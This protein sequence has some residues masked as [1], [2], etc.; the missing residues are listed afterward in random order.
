LG[1]V[2][3]DV[4]QVA[5]PNVGKT[6]PV[7]AHVLQLFHKYLL[8]GGQGGEP[9]LES[10]DFFP[11]RIGLGACGL[12]PSCE[13]R[14]RFGPIQPELEQ[15]SHHVVVGMRK[16]FFSQPRNGPAFPSAKAN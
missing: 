10:S 3:L 13:E 12:L 16:L 8:L 14:F 5:R 4:Y 11:H 9:V 2:F 1:N 6:P 15:L 7:A